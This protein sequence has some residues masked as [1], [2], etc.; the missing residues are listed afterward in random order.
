M[1]KVLLLISMTLLVGAADA[2]GLKGL[3]NKARQKIDKVAETID[4]VQTNVTN[5]VDKV[6]TNVTNA[7]DKMETDVNTI[8]GKAPQESADSAGVQAAETTGATVEPTTQAAQ[9][10]AAVTTVSTQEEVEAMLSQV[11]TNAADMPMKVVTKVRGMGTAALGSTI[12]TD[13]SLTLQGVD[14]SNCVC[15]VMMTNSRWKDE[16]SL[17]E[18]SQLSTSVCSNFF[19]L[20]DSV[21]GNAGTFSVSVP[22]KSK[23]LIGKNSLLY[24]RSY[25][26]DTQTLKMVGMSDFVQYKPESPLPL[27]K[28]LTTEEEALLAGL[29]WEGFNNFTN[30][31]TEISDK[32][33]ACNGAHV[34]GVCHYSTS[35]EKENC[36]HC[37]GSGVCPYYK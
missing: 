18:F 2:Q 7:V 26:L 5:A 24:L 11:A 31:K 19:E 23:G 14:K 29:I 35:E 34:C 4:K 9:T 25:V 30:S 3:L 33:S 12:D 22:L 36:S 37:Q 13:V 6:E 20:K 8:L 16:L 32:C 17:K 28:K 10:N 1:K 21:K 27:P 15:F